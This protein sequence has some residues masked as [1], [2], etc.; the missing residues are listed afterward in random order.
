MYA[1]F[2]IA[3]CLILAF[4]INTYFYIRPCFRSREKPRI[5]PQLD[6]IIGYNFSK[7]KLDD[8]N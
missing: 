5:T 1:P 7:R 4:L 8:S 3:G 6:N 2:G